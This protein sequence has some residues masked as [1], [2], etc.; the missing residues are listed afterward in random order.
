MNILKKLNKSQKN[1]HHKKQFQ[2]NRIRLSILMDISIINS[3]KYMRM[4]ILR[5]LI[6]QKQMMIKIM[7]E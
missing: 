5:M 1:Q 4:Q 3:N 2:Y 7:I 6:I